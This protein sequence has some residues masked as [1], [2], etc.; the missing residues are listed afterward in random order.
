MAEF[1]NRTRKS[2]SIP[3]ALLRRGRLWDL[4]LY[5]LLSQS[6]LGREGFENSGSYKFADHIYR[7]VPAGTGTLGRW[8]D[9]RLLALPAV[10][11]FRNRFLAARDELAGFL[12]DRGGTALNVLSVPCGLPRELV[13]GARMAR[14]RGA[15]LSRVVFHGL[16]LNPE[17]LHEALAF[18]QGQDLK[19]FC[20]H[21]G[22]ALL[23]SSYP[24]GIHFA[25]STGLAEFLD[26]E[27][28]VALYRAVYGCLHVGGTFVSSGMQCRW[29]SQYLLKIAEIQVHYRRA[30]GLEQL[31]RRA[32]FKE[33]STR[34]DSLGIQCMLVAKK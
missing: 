5:C 23:R 12:Q 24:A 21:E 26:D 31:A 4:P 16:D 6:D 33:V 19:N 11:S 25:T 28:L 2:K 34:Y 1:H 10:R 20:C 17:V 18:A 27:K 15:D 30:E 9:A 29:A 8:I 13:E 14:G 3:L 7:H 32:G 22:D